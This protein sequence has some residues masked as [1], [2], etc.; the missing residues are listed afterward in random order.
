M[1]E[2]HPTYQGACQILGR[3]LIIVV[4]ALL[5]APALEAGQHRWWKSERVRVE[6]GLTTDQTTRID[7]VF[8]S[9]LPQLRVER[10]ELD[11]EEAALSRLIASGEV[12]EAEV[13]AQIDEVEAARSALSKTRT[14][15]LFRIRRILSSAQRV[16][17]D[18]LPK[19][20]KRR[21]DG[22]TC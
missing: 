7:G 16:Q 11:R 10:R 12:T 3:G 1:P 2:A 9:T 22:G 14:L 5:V 15:M 8:R 20:L 6:F 21:K 19:S 4:A 18:A 13:A 17:L